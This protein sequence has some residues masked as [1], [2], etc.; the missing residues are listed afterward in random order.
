MHNFYNPHIQNFTKIG[1]NSIF[2]PEFKSNSILKVFLL[3]KG[4]HMKNIDPYFV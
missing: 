4:L 3:F 2:N 1:F